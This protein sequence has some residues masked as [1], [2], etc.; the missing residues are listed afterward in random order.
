MAA[1]A[2]DAATERVAVNL[3]RHLEWQ[4][5]GFSLV[6]L[7]ADVGPSLQLADWLDQRL[8]LQGRA[9]QREEVRDHFVA[10]PEAAVDAL[11]A[12]FAVMSAQPGASWFG[13]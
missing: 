9:L 3:L 5:D 7:F 13:L 12:R 4:A 10:A 2:L 1:L 6:F 8:V 11:V